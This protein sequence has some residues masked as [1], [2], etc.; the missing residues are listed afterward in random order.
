MANLDFTGGLVAG[1]PAPKQSYPGA[2]N[3]IPL[4][5]DA[6]VKTV[7]VSRDTLNESAVIGEPTGVGVITHQTKSVQVPA[8]GGMNSW[9]P[10]LLDATNP[11]ASK[12][13]GDLG[14]TAAPAT[15]NSGASG[16]FR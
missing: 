11:G 5:A 14:N 16:N 2:G 7:A 15:E 8:Y 6:P 13:P 9:G 10:S 4:A 12:V 1:A 3:G